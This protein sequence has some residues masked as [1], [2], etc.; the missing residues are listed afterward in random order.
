MIHLMRHGATTWSRGGRHT[1]TT[2]VELSDEG[3]AQAKAL[4]PA[5]ARIHPAE[6]LTSP[7]SRA[8]ETCRLAG[9]GPVARI[10]GRLAEWDYGAAE[11]RTTAE[12]QAEIP[13]W[14]VWTH[15]LPGGETLDE[16]AARADALIGEL[17]GLDGEALLFGHAHLLRILAVRWCGWAP[18]AAA[19]LVLDPGSISVLGYERQTPAITRWNLVPSQG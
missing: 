13:G 19:H 5:L 18:G 3:V 16:V 8:V 4:A 14:S 1:G 7:R 15:P 12:L 9:F 17:R 10:D 11:G 2:D 6:V